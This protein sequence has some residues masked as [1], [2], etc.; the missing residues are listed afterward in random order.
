MLALVQ[1]SH[2]FTTSASKQARATRASV[3]D[4]RN[5]DANLDESALVGE[6]SRSANRTTAPF[7]S[8][9]RAA[10]SLG[11]ICVLMCRQL[12]YCSALAR[13][14]IATDAME[15]NVRVDRSSSFADAFRHNV[16]PP[17][18]RI[19]DMN[20]ERCVEV[21]RQVTANNIDEIVR[22]TNDTRG[23]IDD[24]VDVLLPA[25]EDSC[26]NL[27]ALFSKIDHMEALMTQIKFSAHE[28]EK[29]VQALRS[30]QN[31]DG[32]MIASMLSR[33]LAAPVQR[34][35]VRP[36]P[37]PLFDIREHPLAFGTV[38]KLI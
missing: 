37:L 31:S 3:V 14:R 17:F 19:S 21:R 4:L 2:A 12:R 27:V 28:A 1:R 35:R 16:V 15:E 13:I 30:E 25:L 11:R 26:A 33:L 18:D 20:S 6:I 24:T 10:H 5:R 32:S 22:T 23:A 36:G 7:A 29:R 34:P 8:L 9:K 38:E